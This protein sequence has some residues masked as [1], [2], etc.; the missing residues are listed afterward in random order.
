MMETIMSIISG[1]AAERA[2]A[3]VAYAVGGA[4]LRWWVAYM[5][6]RIEQWAIGPCGPNATR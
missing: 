1:A 4:T 2:V 3:A 6:W 5:T